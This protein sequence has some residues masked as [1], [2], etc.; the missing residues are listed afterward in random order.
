VTNGGAVVCWGNNANG[1]S[2]PPASAT[3]VVAIAAGKFHNLALRADGTVVGWGLNLYGET[4]PPASLNGV[5]AIA[6]GFSCSLALKSDGTVV[7]WGDNTAGQTNIPASVTNAI[8]I[9]AGNSACFALRSDGTVIGWGGNSL[10]ELNIPAGL[11]GV[12]AIGSGEYH[13]MALKSDGTVV[14]WGYNPFGS[15]TPPVGMSA[16]MAIAVGEEHNVL[17]TCAPAIP[18]SLLATNLGPNQIALSWTDNSWNEDGFKLERALDS[19]GAPGT[20]S[21]LVTLGINV[22]SY[23]NTALALNSKY[24]YRVRSYNAAADSGFSNQVGLPTQPLAP[25]NLA[26]LRSTR[27]KSTCHGRISP[28]TRTVSRSSAHPTAAACRAPGLKSQSSPATPTPTATWDSRATPRTGT[29]SAHSTRGRFSLHQR[30]QCDHPCAAVRTVGSGG[31][32]D[33]QHAD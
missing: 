17:I 3:N 31:D 8:A 1:V 33:Q 6:G 12:V 19:G 16:V 25:I 5:V 7:G 4:N 23:T 26:G 18:Q 28:A 11:S 9:A 22:T 15:L 13:A 24:W 2:T 30:D 21:L 10:G 27:I 32:T 29:A 20:W 14:L